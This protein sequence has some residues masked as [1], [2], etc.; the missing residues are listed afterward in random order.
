MVRDWV[1]PCF[2]CLLAVLIDK[3]LSYTLGL[4]LLFK[5]IV[6]F[7][8]FHGLWLFLNTW[9]YVGFSVFSVSSVVVTFVCAFRLFFKLLSFCFCWPTFFF[10]D[11]SNDLLTSIYKSCLSKVLV[12]STSLFISLIVL[13]QKVTTSSITFK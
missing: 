12:W 1:F 13:L 11:A 10:V 5:M 6:M 9:V 3:S 2:S 7:C 8:L 4:I